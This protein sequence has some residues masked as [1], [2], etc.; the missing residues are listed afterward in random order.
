MRRLRADDFYAAVQ[1]LYHFFWDDFCDWYIELTKAD[2]AA[3][4]DSI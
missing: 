3:S 2:V 1:T 4:E